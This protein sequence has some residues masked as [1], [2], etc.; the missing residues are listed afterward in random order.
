MITVLSTI[1]ASLFAGVQ[2]LLE[3]KQDTAKELALAKIQ[4][5][6]EIE[7]AKQ[8]VILSQN[9]LETQE[10]V[11]TQEQYK[12]EASTKSSEVEEY[13][14]FSDAVTQTSSLWQG[15]SKLADIANFI[16]VTARPIL[17]YIL[18]IFT[19]T[20]GCRLIFSDS[21]IDEK[22]LVIFD[23]VLAEFSAAMSYWFVKRSFDKRKAA[24]FSPTSKK[25]LK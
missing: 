5:E 12:T 7:L 1:A 6:K 11:T 15:T 14:A 20:I 2:N 24:E 23:M 3:H 10:S 9:Q 19:I 18:L 17:T 21:E 4:S 13:K 25:K 16:T 22:T 8:G